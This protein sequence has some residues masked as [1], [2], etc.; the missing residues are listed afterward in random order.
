MSRRKKKINEE[1]EI[2]SKSQ[3]KRDAQELKSLA[4]KL[5]KLR[6]A[7][8]AQLPLEDPIREAITEARQIRSNI[9]GKRQ[10][11]FVA[12]LLR[13]TDATKI[14]ES[15]EAFENEAQQLTARQHRSEAWR[16]FLLDSGDLA[17]GQLLSERQDADAQAIRQLIR[18]AQ[19]EAKREKPPAS[20]RALFRLLLDM[21]KNTALPSLQA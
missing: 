12:K 18:N 20:A 19:S 15:I 8:L 17:L 2:V 6:P 13:R 5:I 4:S 10:L 11:Q 3:R 9:A 7:R 21:D 14:I 1:I 16:D